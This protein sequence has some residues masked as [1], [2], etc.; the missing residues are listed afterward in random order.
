LLQI[1]FGSTVLHKQRYTAPGTYSVEL[2][3]PSYQVRGKLRIEMR[4]RFQQ[5]FS[6]TIP[7]SFNSNYDRSIK[8]L[9][10]LPFFLL[11]AVLVITK[12][13]TTMRKEATL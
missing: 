13:T 10:A 5:Y 12:P 7:I 11:I 8:W 2:D 4:N 3:S 6:D 9:I 1:K